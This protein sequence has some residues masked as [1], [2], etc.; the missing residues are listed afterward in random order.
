MKRFNYI[1]ILI[2]SILSL[3]IALF[4]NIEHTLYKYLIIFSIV[5]V[6][7]LPYIVKKIFKFKLD[8]SI[9]ILYLVFVFFAHFLGTI[10]NLYGKIAIYDKLM[11]TFSGVMTSFLALIILVKS[12]NYKSKSI[13][14]N[15]LYIIAITCTVAVLWEMF[16][17]TCD[18][19]FNKDAQ[20]VALT[21]VADTMT[22]VIVAFLGSCM[23]SLFYFYE[24]KL[25]KN[26]IIKRFIK[27]I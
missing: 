21:G 23:F 17:F 8:E 1:L 3:Y 12:K 4:G 20:R 25:K 22:D 19:L 2:V 7:L 5:P 26:L 6:M 14:Y 13:W 16:E 24:E 11:H 15:I 10:V 18:N 9:I 27:S